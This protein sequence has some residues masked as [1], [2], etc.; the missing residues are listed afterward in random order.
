MQTSE[1][2]FSLNQMSMKRPTLLEI[3]KT[4]LYIGAVGYGGPAILGLMKRIIVH[5]KEWISEEEFMN[6]LSLA[7]IL[8][9]C[10]SASSPSSPGRHGQCLPFP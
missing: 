5:D 8:S 3:L 6:A 9:S 4:A 2:D 1:T 7:Q 10:N